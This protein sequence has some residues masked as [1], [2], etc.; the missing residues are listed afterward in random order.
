M[1]MD[2]IF[3][4]CGNDCSACPRYVLHPFEKTEEELRR[5]AELWA[6]IGYRDHVVTNEEIAC[7]GCKPENWCRYHVVKC[8]EDKGIRTCA[9]CDAYPCENIKECF[10]VT[11]S[12]E[13]MCR[14][15]CT[16]EEFGRLKRAFFEKEEN[17]ASLAAH[18]Q[19]GQRGQMTSEVKCPECPQEEGQRGQMTPEVKCPKEA[20]RPQRSNAPNDPVRFDVRINGLE[21]NAVYSRDSIENIF[22]PLLRKLTKMRREKN[23]RVLA[24]F[25][26]PPGAG[27]STLLSFLAKLA[28]EDEQSDE[29][30]VLGMDG[31]HRRQAYLVSRTVVRDGAEIPMASIKGAPQTFDLEKLTERVQNIAAGRTCGWPVYDRRLHDPVDDAMTVD[32]EIVLIEGNY[33]LLDEPGWRDL[34]NYADYTVLIRADAELLRKRLVDRKAMGMT[35]REEAEKFVEFSDMRNVRTCLERSGGADLVL[36][37][38]GDG[39]FAVI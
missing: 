21:V 10:Q 28:E 38:V 16:D 33:L 35:S 27:K 6:K 15:V 9:E 20:K 29:V 2:G 32:G 17:M 36:E 37:M 8:C 23:G 5:T 31:F 13:P 19:R 11:K 1:I 4:A 24:L 3:A 39:E 25:A 26:A 34:R 30:Q 7:N 22:V 18:E 12:F 14:R